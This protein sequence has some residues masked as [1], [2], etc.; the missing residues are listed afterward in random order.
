MKTWYTMQSFVLLPVS[1]D[2]VDGFH[3]AVAS[4]PEGKSCMGLCLVQLCA[5]YM[6]V[7]TTSSPYY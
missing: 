5:K 1:P 7:G 6:L 4:L 3:G 2:G